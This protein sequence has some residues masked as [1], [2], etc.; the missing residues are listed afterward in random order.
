MGKL[1]EFKEER[2]ALYKKVAELDKMIESLANA[3]WFLEEGEDIWSVDQFGNIQ[4]SRW[5]NQAWSN[6]AFTQ[7][8]IFKTEIGARLE[9]QSRNL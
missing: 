7:G 5:G 9:A 2:A 4:W 1:E 3:Q 8:H 6:V